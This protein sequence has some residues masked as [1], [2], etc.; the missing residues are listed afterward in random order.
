MTNDQVYIPRTRS[1]LGLPP[2]DP[3]KEDI[4]GSHITEEVM[5]EL[6]E[7]LGD[8]PLGAVLTPAS[9]LVSP[10]VIVV[11]LIYVLMK[12][13]FSLVVFLPTSLRTPL[14]RF[15]TPKELIVSSWCLW[16]SFIF[17]VDV[18]GDHRFQPECR[19]VQASP[20]LASYVVQRWYCHLDRWTSCL[21][22]PTWFLGG[23]YPLCCPLP[24]VHN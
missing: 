1:E 6:W 22:F 24:L 7:A 5:K 21:G 23:P 2:L 4:L 10:T 3:S 15:V 11:W 18:N 12:A 9:Y 14:A 20:I 13:K 8:S 17:M 16:A 19:Y